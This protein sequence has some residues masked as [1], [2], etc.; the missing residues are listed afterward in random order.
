MGDDAVLN[1]GR[2]INNVTITSEEKGGDKKMK[3][4]KEKKRKHSDNDPE[5][6]A[7]EVPMGVGDDFELGEGDKKKKKRKVT[8]GDVALDADTLSKSIEEGMHHKDDKK[9]KK[10]KDASDGIQGSAEEEGLSNKEV[11]RKKNKNKSK[12]GSDDIEISAEE[13]LNLNNEKRKKKKS[14][15][16]SEDIEISAEEGLDL[17]DEKK[18]KKKSKDVSDDIQISAGKGLNLND[19]KKKKKKSKD[20]SDD[21]QI[22]AE[23]GS[24]RKDEKKKKKKKSEDVSDDIPIIAE[25]G[26]NLK[27]KK[28]K[29]KKTKDASDDIQINLEDGL[30]LKDEKKKKKKSKDVSDGIEISTEEGLSHDDEKKKKKKK[31]SEDVSED[32]D[33]SYRK[34][35]KNKSH[36]AAKESEEDVTNKE[37]EQKDQKKKRKKVTFNKDDESQKAKK[38]GIVETQDEEGEDLK[39][40]KKDKN[41]KTGEK[42]KKVTFADEVEILDSSD[43]KRRVRKTVKDDGLVRGKRFSKEEDAMILK[44]IEEY[45]ENHTLGEEGVNMLKNCRDHPEVKNCWKEIASVLPYRPYTAIYYRAHTLLTVNKNLKWDPETIKFIH[46]QYEKEGADWKTMAEKLGTHRVHVKDAWRRTKYLNKKKGHW[47]QAEYQKLFDLVNID[48]RMKAEEERQSKHGMLRDNIAWTAIS[49]TLETRTHMTCCMKWYEQLSSPMV[50]QGLWADV[51]DYR[52]LIELHELDACHAED[53]DWDSLLEHRSGEICRKRW[54]QMVKHLGEHKQK[55]F[56]E[57]VETLHA[58]YCPD[59]LFISVSNCTCDLDAQAATIRMICA[60]LSERCTK[61]YYGSSVPSVVPPIPLRDNGKFKSITS[62]SD[63][64]SARCR[65]T[66]YVHTLSMITTHQNE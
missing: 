32:I 58:R 56:A 6:T 5:L 25:D 18:K 11:K 38:K 43:K 50:S 45:I 65:S 28:K 39:K 29:K 12:D 24:N 30:N 41:K 52:L 36:D 63:I 10:T 3:K 51:D 35:K 23:E 66:I 54:N 37:G 2:D 64:L 4:N 62:W 44:S 57:Q 1:H 31:K 21:I 8:D 26:S 47:S 27:D 22:S 59:I 49:E 48:L 20:V 14:K 15:D 33:I 13:G 9:K 7:D 61:S 53:V 40:K 42:T 46:D 34:R 60:L 17:N 55:S 16:V 19:E